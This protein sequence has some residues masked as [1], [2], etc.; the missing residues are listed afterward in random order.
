TL[1]GSQYRTLIETPLNLAGREEKSLQVG[2]YAR[3]N[4]ARLRSEMRQVLIADGLFADE[5][6]AMLK[7]WEL[8]YFK[9]P[10]LRVF[11]TLP[12]AWTDAVL[13]L[14]CSVLAEVSRTMIG[15]IEL[16]TP[17]Q[18]HQ[19]QTIS[20]SKIS[21]SQW[22][23]EQTGGR[24]DRQAE[25]ARLFE[26]QARLQEL[27]ITIPRDYQAFLDLGRFRSALV[28]DHATRHPDSALNKFA[29]AYGL[30]YYDGGDSPETAQ[31]TEQPR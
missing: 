23:Y 30:D 27:K 6:D 17:Q 9:S 1:T 11:Y 26:G 16:V 25:L 28:L 19:L 21:T 4:L 8:A 2:T 5:A 18:R 7:T 13:P 29:E 14:K 12:Q 22:L 15:R 3:D 20:E 24:A 31:A 10:G